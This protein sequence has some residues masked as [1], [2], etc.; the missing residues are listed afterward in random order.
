MIP[1]SKQISAIIES[2]Q[3]R[4]SDPSWDEYHNMAKKSLEIEETHKRRQSRIERLHEIRHNISADA[5]SILHDWALDK[6]ALVPTKAMTAVSGWLAG[7]R[8]P[9]LVLAGGV[10]A[11]KTVAASW[12][13]LKRGGVWCPARDLAARYRPFQS[14]REDGIRRF[15]IR[16]HFLVLD[17][18]GTEQDRDKRIFE[19]VEAIADMRDDKDMKTLITTNLPKQQLREIYGDRF[20]DRLNACA[21]YVSVGSESLRH[22]TGGFR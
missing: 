9:V 21:M 1:I 3:S 13:F 5:K 20:T 2:L 10:G 17:D 22:K 8:K 6:T 12:A 19:A 16:S 14:D 11:G 18:L 15:N 4:A 7:D